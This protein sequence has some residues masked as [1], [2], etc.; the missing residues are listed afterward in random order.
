MWVSS[1][2]HARRAKAEQ[3]LKPATCVCLRQGKKKKTRG[4]YLSR[5]AV[6]TLTA[7]HVPAKN[8]FLLDFLFDRG[9]SSRLLT[10]T[11]HGLFFTSNEKSNR[12]IKA[13]RGAAG[14]G[15]ACG[16]P[17]LPALLFEQVWPCVRVNRRVL[18][19][20]QVSYCSGHILSPEAR[21]NSISVGPGSS[22]AAG[23]HPPP[24]PCPLLSPSTPSSFVPGRRLSP[25]R[26]GEF[27][28]K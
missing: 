1:S 8:C 22:S 15:G 6:A 25:P 19:K 16:A 24:P 3:L 13:N 10:Q 23:S 17:C 11:K 7:S 18:A 26:R 12:S 2:S 28:N 5:S 20:P 9:N 14:G 27:P 21:C 4:V